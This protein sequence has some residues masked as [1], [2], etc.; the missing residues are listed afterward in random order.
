MKLKQYL[1]VKRGVNVYCIEIN[2]T[3]TP[4]TAALVK[5]HIII[6]FSKFTEYCIMVIFIVVLVDHKLHD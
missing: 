4:P 2:T 3:K 1:Y 5:W 6:S